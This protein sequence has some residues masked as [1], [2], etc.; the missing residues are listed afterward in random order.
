MMETNALP[1]PDAD[2]GN[3]HCSPEASGCRYFTEDG[4]GSVGT[5]GS[6]FDPVVFPPHMDSYLR[7]LMRRQPLL[8]VDWETRDF[9][10]ELSVRFISRLARHGLH[11][12]PE[13]HRT[14]IIRRMAWQ[15]G[16]DKL[17][18]LQ[19][20]KRDCRRQKSQSMESFAQKNGDA[21]P[22]AHLCSTET[23][24]KI[25]ETV[26]SADWSLLEMRSSG[27]A[28]D[29][30]A[31]LAGGTASSQRMRHRRLVRKLAKLHA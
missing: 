18:Q 2:A 4:L 20:A 21:D 9:F 13:D 8:R 11:Q 29:E 24:G 27:L 6:A 19:R 7:I 30:I 1:L 31:R 14:A 23:L 16:K 25:R 12:M 28:W 22:L 3:T 15:L 26:P 10:Q 17:R 5:D